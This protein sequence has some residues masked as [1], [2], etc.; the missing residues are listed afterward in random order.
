MRVNVVGR[1]YGI[2]NMFLRNG[3]EVV[4]PL[5][6][7]DL[8]QFVGGE[9]VDPALY[10]ETRH[11]ATFSNPARDSIEAKI[12]YDNVGH[13]PVAG[14]CRGGQLL[15]VLCGGKMW[16]HVNN[17]ALQ[18]THEATNLIGGEVL[19]VT[20]T[21]HQMMIPHASARVLLIADVATSKE[22]PVYSEVG[23]K[24]DDIEALFYEEQKVLCFQ[25]HPEYLA[26]GSDCQSLYFDY[27]RNFLLV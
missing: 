18:G 22:R 24:S 7:A 13:T 21:H 17:H 1:D 25:P 9:D 11:A 6:D 23:K 10:N 20:S 12:F 16:Q 14:I 27:L 15:N 26:V 19:R 5:E 4:G 2:I 8:I 3:W